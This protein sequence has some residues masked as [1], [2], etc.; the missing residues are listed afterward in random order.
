MPSTSVH[1]WEADFHYG[2]V[3]WLAVKAGFTDAHA[4]IIAAGSESPDETAALS[5]SWVVPA[6]VCIRKSK[7]ASRH[8][9]HYHFPSPKFVP[10]ERGK[11]EVVAGNRENYAN[12]WV[13]QEITI[14]ANDA[15]IETRLDRLGASLHPLAD[16][17]S[18]R[19]TPSSIKFR[20]FG[21]S[22][23]CPEE[24]VWSHP[25]NRGGPTSHDA[26]HTHKFPDKMGYP[27]DAMNAAANIY[28]Y[29]QRYLN[30]HNNPKRVGYK[31]PSWLSLEPEVI[32]FARAET[33]KEKYNWFVNQHEL[34][35]VNLSWDKYYSTYPCFLF[36]STTL[37]W[38]VE[39]PEPKPCQ[40]G[41]PFDDPGIVY[42]GRP[43]K[44]G[45]F[46]HEN[47][48]D[49]IVHKQVNKIAAG[50]P[51]NPKGVASVL[52]SFTDANKIEKMPFSI[53]W[54]Q[55]VLGMWLMR[56]H[57]KATAWGHGMPD[58]QNGFRNL[59]NTVRARF[60]QRKEFLD[61]KH[62]GEAI[63]APG[64]AVPYILTP[65]PKEAGSE[66]AHAVL[67]KFRHAPR[68][69]LILTIDKDGYKNWKIE[70]LMWTTD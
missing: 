8:V 52:E 57:G 48:T 18:H 49:W 13:R 54:A 9:Q 3:K 7:E 33:A 17:W 42:A 62:L 31:S 27:R 6:L 22:Y 26:D 45:E 24:L 59:L 34:M 35:G 30:K 16:S 41:E 1:A 23:S 4:E 66:N 2:L 61:F 5:A 58:N 21:I 56:D 36:K 64:A 38:K 10:S 12:R 55:T 40:E 46:V 47:L 15:K 20:K 43:D 11:R 25:M 32:N 51:M 44:L 68:D 53:E 19:G 14:S 29:L 63:F 69:T 65:L 37:K 28:E 70:G 60:D 50:G 67:F 39:L